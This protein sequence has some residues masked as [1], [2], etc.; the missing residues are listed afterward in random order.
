MDVTGVVLGGIPIA[1]YA[2]DSYK[3]CLRGVHGVLGY[4][5]TLET[6]R[7]HIFIQKM[8][9]EVTLQNIGLHADDGQLPTQ[10]ELKDH[11]QRLYPDNCE[12]FMDILAQM[13]GILAKLLYKLNVDSQGKACSRRFSS[14]SRST[15][16]LMLTSYQPKWTSDPAERAAWNW[17]RVKRGLGSSERDDLIQQLQY[18]NTA[19]ANV[20]ERPEIPQDEDGP[21]VQKLQAQFNDKT[22]NIIRK[23]ARCV[24][25]ALAQTWR[26]NCPQHRA[27]LELSW[28]SDKSITAGPF[29]LAISALDGSWQ[30][31][32]AHVEHD[33]SVASQCTQQLNA[34]NVTPGMAVSAESQAGKKKVS[35]WSPRKP[36]TVE[37]VTPAVNTIPLNLTPAYTEVTCLCYFISSNGESRTGLVQFPDT[38]DSTTMKRL[39][40]RCAQTH[41]RRATTLQQALSADHV[42]SRKERFAIAAA[43]TWAV[44][45]LCGTP[46]LKD[47]W[48]GSKVI[49]LNV[50]EASQQVHA[51][52]KQPSI[53]CILTSRGAAQTG[54]GDDGQTGKMGRVQNKILFALGVLLMELC[55]DTTL[56]NLRQESRDGSLARSVGLEPTDVDDFELADRQSD[57]VYLD[58]GQ[59]YGYAVQ[60]CLRCEFPGR[61]RTKSFDFEQ[62]RRHFFN[63]VVAPVHVAYIMQPG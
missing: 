20:F 32:T 40:L 12:K 16:D 59:S 63:G 2:L 27:N 62:F 60:R 47:D 4:E 56:G 15:R 41:T 14:Q 48:A 54:G 36:A 43:A 38:E 22:C 3:R 58:A 33:Q 53:S 49:E 44:L 42:L 10:V 9:L 55:L 50:D 37:T 30:Q 18:W 46:W 6:F 21:L 51:S 13:E 11:L 8:Q 25:N 34:A 17:R 61:D 23:N 7:R 31:L 5:A 45:Y 39:I 26:C 35:F 24:Y 52:S 19:L 57:R 29:T 1:L 28:H